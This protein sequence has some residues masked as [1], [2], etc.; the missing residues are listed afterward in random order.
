MTPRL[1][2]PA[3]TGPN[4]FARPSLEMVSVRVKLVSGGSSRRT[5]F[6][7]RW[8]SILLAA[9]S[10]CSSPQ[11]VGAR[12]VPCRASRACGARTAA[13]GPQLR[14]EKPSTTRARV[15]TTSS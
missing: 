5:L 2:S 10:V 4:S 9:R 1:K 6:V 15:N 11:P 8:R 3:N 12:T 7:G 14:F 13:E